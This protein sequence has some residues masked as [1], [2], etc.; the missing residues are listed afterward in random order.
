MSMRSG[1][2][3]TARLVPAEDML[4]WVTNDV[5]D[6]NPYYVASFV[7]SSLATGTLHRSLLGGEHL[8][9]PSGL[10]GPL[11]CF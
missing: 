7:T 1:W 9:P 10:T 2:S 3:T 6:L 4:Q 8:R 11:A 5:I